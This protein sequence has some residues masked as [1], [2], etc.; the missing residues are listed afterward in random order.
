VL[1]DTALAG[2]AA[3]SVDRPKMAAIT[4]MALRIASPDRL[5]GAHDPS[6]VLTFSQ[7]FLMGH[8]ASGSV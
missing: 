1:S 6:E 3:N 2:A 4:G 7:R 5:V 8:F